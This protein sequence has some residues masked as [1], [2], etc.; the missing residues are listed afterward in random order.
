MKA[1]DEGGRPVWY[2]VHSAPVRFLHWV[3]AA[4]IVILFMSG[5][6]IFNAHPALYWGEDS[7]FEAPFLAIRADYDEHDEAAGFTSVLGREWKTTGWLGL[8]AA[9]ESR[10]FPSWITLPP[11]RSLPRARQ[12]HFTFAWL[13]VAGLIAYGV[14]GIASGHI[15]GSLIPGRD[16]WRKLGPSLLDHLRLRFGKGEGGYSGIQKLVYSLVVLVLLPI[17][18]ATGLAMSPALGAA[19]WGLTDVFGGRQSAR[20][21]HFICAWL[22]ALFAVIHVLMVILSGPLANLR[23]MITGWRKAPPAGTHEGDTS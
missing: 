6:Q 13:L 18:I 19:L 4:S 20:T 23:G 9:G 5:L 11:Q 21:I 10:A 22:L 8:T 15:R 1:Q 2:Y 17:A 12:W 3:M 14:Y 16:D 7:D